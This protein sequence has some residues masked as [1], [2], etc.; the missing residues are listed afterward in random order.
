MTAMNRVV[1]QVYMCSE[2]TETCLLRCFKVC[3]VKYHRTYVTGAPLGIFNDEIYH[4]DG[5]LACSQIAACFN[6]K[7]GFFDFD[8]KSMY[9]CSCTYHLFHRGNHKFKVN[10][11]INP[12]QS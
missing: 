6:R 3:A 7:N 9:C 2:S 4:V 10:N 11:G 12:V 1:H 5:L 8:W